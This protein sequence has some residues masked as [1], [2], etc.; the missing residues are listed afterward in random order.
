MA[1][2]TATEDYGTARTVKDA[3]AFL[4]DPFLTIGGRETCGQCIS[5]GRT[6]AGE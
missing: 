4:D 2:V 5:V 6:G 1:R 3:E